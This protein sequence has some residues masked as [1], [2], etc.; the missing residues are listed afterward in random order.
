MMHQ[1]I[2]ERDGINIEALD[3]VLRSALNTTYIG[4]STRPN[5]VILH[6]IQSSTPEQRNQAR[7][8][9][10]NHDSSQHTQTQQRRQQ[11]RQRLDQLRRDNDADI[12]EDDYAL[13]LPLFRALAQKIAWLEQEIR[14]IRNQ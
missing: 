10:L 6:L 7:Q 8:L 14:E 13:E 3:E 9:V 12:N 11:R 5:E 4:L 2:I 1:I